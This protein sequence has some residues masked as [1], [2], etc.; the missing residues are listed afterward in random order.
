MP[1]ETIFAFARGE[2]DRGTV[3]EHSLSDSIP[4]LSRG[5][6]E[7][8]E[9]LGWLTIAASVPLTIDGDIAKFVPTGVS[10]RKLFAGQALLS[11]WAGY[12]LR[13]TINK[14]TRLFPLPHL[15]LSA[16]SL[17]SRVP[18]KS[19]QIDHGGLAGGAPSEGAAAS[20]H[21]IEVRDTARTS[22]TRTYR[23]RLYVPVT[24]VRTVTVCTYQ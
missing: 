17:P 2:F 6:Y 20:S 4:F 10:L 1:A 5:T 23:D 7:L 15:D 12:S 16:A 22:S 9:R 13:L 19:I 21:R 24:P 18:I 11:E 14:D 8:A 3:I